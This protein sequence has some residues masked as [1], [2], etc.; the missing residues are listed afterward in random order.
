MCSQAPRNGLKLLALADC[1]QNTE[2]AGLPCCKY[3][4]T[5]DPAAVHSCCKLGAGYRRPSAAPLPR[6]SSPCR[7]SA[8]AAAKSSPRGCPGGCSSPLPV[9]TMAVISTVGTRGVL[10]S[11]NSC[12]YASIAGTTPTAGT[13]NSRGGRG[14]LP[15]ASGIGAPLP[16]AEI[17][18]SAP[19]GSGAELCRWLR[20]QACARWPCHVHRPAKHMCSVVT[21]AKGNGTRCGSQHSAPGWSSMST[22]PSRAISVTA[23][24]TCICSGRGEAGVMVSV[25]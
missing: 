2:S 18:P 1:L 15:A 19:A 23:S 14:R 8:A 20:L 13:Q 6:T 12:L 4:S 25:K 22:R 11:P 7:A 5:R 16:A 17:G 9:S 3:G 10:A 21:D 24:R